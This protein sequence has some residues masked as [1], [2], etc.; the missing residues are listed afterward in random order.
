MELKQRMRKF[1]AALL[2]T[3]RSIPHATPSRQPLFVEGCNWPTAPTALAVADQATLQIV[4]F[5]TRALAPEQL[6]DPQTELFHRQE[7]AK[8]PIGVPL[9]ALA[10]GPRTLHDSAH[11]RMNISCCAA[12]AAAADGLLYYSFCADAPSWPATASASASDQP[13]LPPPVVMAAPTL[14]FA[15]HDGLVNGLAMEPAGSPFLS[16]LASTGDDACLKVWDVEG[17]NE[18]TPVRLLEL[19]SPGLA[20]RW[21]VEHPELLLS[22]ELEGGPRLCDLRRGTMA[23][24]LSAPELPELCY[25]ADWSPVQPHLVGCVGTEQ[26]LVWD[27]RQPAVPLHQGGYPSAFSG[28]PSPATHFRFSPKSPSTFAISTGH[29]VFKY[30]LPTALPEAVPIASSHIGAISWLG[31]WL[32]AGGIR[33][34]SLNKCSIRTRAF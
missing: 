11:D 34:Y 16:R 27:L 17:L 10:W 19:H 21:H 20:V 28:V 14:R 31:S 22:L 2:A 25:D 1:S 9:T 15:G 23:T 4:R 8:I 12:P 6:H 33:E 29:A 32:V 30:E 3:A 5:S 18:A 24:T 7:L 26:W 13:P